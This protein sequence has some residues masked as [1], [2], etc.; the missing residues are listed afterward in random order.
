GYVASEIVKNGG[1]AVC[2]PIAPY[3]EVRKD[4]RKMVAPVGGFLLVHVATSLEECE[5]RDRKGM[6]AAA[7]AKLAKG[8]KAGFTGLDD[9]Y[10]VPADA[11]LAI[12]TLKLSAEEAADAV[13]GWLGKEGYFI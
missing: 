12:D 1:I 7:R 13:L 5:R 10:E 9:P 6:Y 11:E 8:E 4:V 2:A 3:D